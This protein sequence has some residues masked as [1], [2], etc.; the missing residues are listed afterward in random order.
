VFSCVD[1]IVALGACTSTWKWVEL[2]IGPFGVVVVT[3]IIPAVET[4]MS[5]ARISACSSRAEMYVVARGCLFQ[6]TVEPG[7]KFAPYIVSVKPVPPG[8]TDCGFVGPTICGTGYPGCRMPA[9]TVL[10]RKRRAVVVNR[11]C[12]MRRMVL[13]S[14]ELVK[15][16]DS[17]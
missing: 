12:F 2:V 17:A 6:L 4:A 7:M 11:I 10:V 15:M 8:A 13:R 16:K 5:D 14:R 1:P 9:H 3:V